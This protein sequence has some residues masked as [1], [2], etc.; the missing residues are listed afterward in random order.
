MIGSQALRD[1]GDIKSA[2]MFSVSESRSQVIIKVISH[3]FCHILLVKINHRF[4]SHS[5][6]RGH[7]GQGDLR[8]W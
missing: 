3:H 5:R 6:G 2:R 1:L 7:S 8:G 4:F